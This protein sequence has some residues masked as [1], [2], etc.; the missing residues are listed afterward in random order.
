MRDLRFQLPWMCVA[1]MTCGL[2]AVPAH[3]RWSAPPAAPIPL[4]V[5]IEDT[6]A[7][8]GA[9]PKRWRILARSGPHGSVLPRGVESVPEGA[10]RSFDFEPDEGYHVSK[11]WVDGRN[12]GSLPGFVLTDIDANHTI[13]AEFVI[14]TYR[15]GVKSGA[16]G[17]VLPGHPAPVPH[18]GTV[19]LAL[20]PKPGYHLESLFV[21]GSP[22]KP[23]DQ[24]TF[25]NVTASHDVEARFDVNT[26][27][28]QAS[29]G[30]HAR[31]SPSGPIEVKHGES[32]TFLLTA[33]P[34]YQ[35]KEVLLD[36]KPAPADMIYT[37]SNVHADHR[38]VARVE[39][40]VA[41]IASP[42]GGERWLAGESAFIHWL[43]VESEMRDP[44][45]QDSA[46][47]RVSFHGVDGP[48]ETIWRG[49]FRAGSVEWTVPDVT[50]D[51]LLVSIAKL[52][53]AAIWAARFS[54]ELPPGSDFAD[55][56]VKIRSAGTPED[57]GRFSLRAVP[58]PAP[59]GPV[60]LEVEL[61][62]A[63]PATMEVFSVAG[64]LVWRQA[65]SWCPTGQRRFTWDGL[66]ASGERVDPGV[67]FA[68][69]TARPG[70]R[71]C[72][73]VLLP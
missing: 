12:L 34:G 3:A 10:A 70:R 16:N 59:V 19:R 63:G 11:V 36:E 38:L 21:D 42:E 44:Q 37:L 18:G 61:P 24:L 1:T 5:P 52:D 53:S 15:V 71:N 64:K 49:P 69:V 54:I 68:R 35:V 9:N 23:T 6:P 45:A 56:L 20:T 51:S 66:L 65:M 28:I 41:R 60:Q 14:N 58:S 26:Y 72:R 25:R 7:D 32:Q 8:A 67:Y 62:Y 2:V 55:G 50:C 46:E 29:A 17:S 22:V 43:P 73:L 30:V 57:G 13:L 27:T 39:H 48:W 4:I 31:I 47:V 40:Q 33:D